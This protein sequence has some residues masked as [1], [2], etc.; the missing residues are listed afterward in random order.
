[1]GQ[2][3]RKEPHRL[4]EGFVALRGADPCIRNTSV[5]V[6]GTSSGSRSVRCSTGHLV[7]HNNVTITLL[8][9]PL[10][11]C[12]LGTT[13][14]QTRKR[15]RWLFAVTLCRRQRHA[16]R[17]IFEGKEASCRAPYGGGVGKKGR[18]LTQRGQDNTTVSY[19]NS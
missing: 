2:N 18:G 14:A 1:M 13:I 11:D 8:L 17:R 6:N 7:F 3:H 5:F 9:L 15:R 10:W 4:Q 12:R 19:L 16:T